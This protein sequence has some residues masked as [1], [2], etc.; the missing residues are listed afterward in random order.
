MFSVYI[1][2]RQVQ[3]NNQ[4]IRLGMSHLFKYIRV[5]SPLRINGLTRCIMMYLLH[6]YCIRKVI[7]S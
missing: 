4:H 5:W 2:I 7:N 1:I 3:S 6:R